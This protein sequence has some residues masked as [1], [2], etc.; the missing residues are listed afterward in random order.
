[1]RAVVLSEFGPPENLVLREV[2]DPV[3]GPGQVFIE[4]A[5]ASIT[6]IETQVRAGTFALR[7]P[8]DM[9]VVLGNGVAGTAL[10]RQVVS[11]TGGPAA[12][13]NAS[14]WTPANRAF[15]SLPLL[16]RRS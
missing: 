15:D 13:P 14:R 4:V 7:P 5:A 1:M 9:P 6:F 11:T 3:A 8:R 12:T 2:P 16:G 10:G